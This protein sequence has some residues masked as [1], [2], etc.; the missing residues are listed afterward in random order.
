MAEHRNTTATVRMVLKACENI[1]VDTNA[2][3]QQAGIERAVAQDPDGEVGF[4]QMRHFWQTAYQMSGDPC[5][6]LNTAL[7]VETGTYQCYDYLMLHANTIKQGLENFCRYM[8]LINTW[9]ALQLVEEKDQIRVQ[10][11]PATGVLPPPTPEFVFG[12]LVRRIRMMLADEAWV[13]ISV[14][15][16]KPAPA[17]TTPHD[18]FFRCPVQYEAPM[19]EFLIPRSSWEQAVPSADARLLQVLDQHAQMLL[20]QR[21]MP[22][23]FVA[24][25]R[26]EIMREIHGGEAKRDSIAQRLCMSGR[27]LQRRL[28]EQGIVFSELA[29]QVRL[30]LAKSHLLAKDMPL[31][32]IGF[33][34]G[35]AEQSS[36]TRAF[37]R[38]TGQT[39]ME[40]RK[41]SVF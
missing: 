34:L 19:A 27:T 36:F 6:A 2:L 35:F 37:K 5:L 22:D 20:A 17:N 8:G 26:K 28:D 10:I 15:F 39:P 25:V 3:L 31:A 11:L 40:F 29:D 4:E 13:P 18:E 7:Q 24:Q 23:D 1:G 21:P 41:A 9:I 16:S 12:I 32:E 33:L 14:R 38:W 30:E